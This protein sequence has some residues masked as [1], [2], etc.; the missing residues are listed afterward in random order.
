MAELVYFTGPMNCG[1]STLALQL[2]YTESSAGRQGRRFTR[3]D[4]A[5][6]AVISSRI[7]IRHPAIEVS[8]AFDFWN[9]VIGELTHG[10][11]VDY[12]VCDEVHFYRADQID[13][14]ARLVDG[15]QLDVY[16]FG[17]LSDF[18]TRLFPATRRLVELSDRVE[19]LP[20]RPRCWCGEPATHN[21]RTVNGQMVISGSQTMVGDIGSSPDAVAY[22]VLCRRHHRRRMTAQVARVTLSPEP[23]PFG[24]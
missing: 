5:G 18:R 15:L 1:K 7:G 12:L 24:E 19:R 11:R 2:D 10:R 14:L 21:A 23:L 3:D 4:R 22:E 6:E 9:Y 17:I 8:D 16:C 20:V 13:Q